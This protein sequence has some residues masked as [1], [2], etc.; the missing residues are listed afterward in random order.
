[1]GTTAFISGCAGT[2]LTAAER[3]FFRDAAPWGLILFARNCLDKAQIRAL[4]ADFREV[5]GRTDAPVLIDQEGGRVQRLK[6]PIWPAYPPAAALGRL[7]DRDEERGRRAAFLLGRLIGEDLDEL[8]ITVDCV[9]VLDIRVPQAHDIIGDRAYGATPAKVVALARA[10][11]EGLSEAGVAPV[12]KHIPG[13]G[14]ALS[15]SHFDLPAVNA[16]LKEMSVTDFA[17]FRGLN[18]L[19]MAMTAHVVYVAIDTE[20]P[21]TLSAVLIDAVIRRSIGFDGLL[22]SDDLS[23]GALSGS[24]GERTV[25]ALRAGCDVALHCN[26]Q[27]DE[28]EA[29]AAAVPALGS[30]A[31]DRAVAALSWANRR[32]TDI[33]GVRAEFAELMDAAALAGEA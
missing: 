24:L 28:M 9:P 27:M 22:M 5:V 19:P 30:R 33:V 13:H 7:F 16:S 11:S 4:V 15:D 12:M 14:R 31:A 32:E 3:A 6:P 2:E 21:A 26:G 20:A 25:G 10:L 23:M 1:V 8:G 18:T 29:V 17:P